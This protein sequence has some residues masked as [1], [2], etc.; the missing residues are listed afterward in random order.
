MGVNRFKLL[1]I[2]FDTDLDKM[3]ILNFSDK[4]SNIK[5]K[6]NYW[7]RRNLTP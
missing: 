7:N 6:L 3:L 5:T 4:L 1:E 2:T